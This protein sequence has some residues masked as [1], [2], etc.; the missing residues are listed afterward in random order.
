[1][2]VNISDVY[3]KTSL[4][5]KSETN[6]LLNSKSNS[7]I[8]TSYYTKTEIN[9]SFDNIYCELYIGNTF[10]DQIEIDEKNDILSTALVFKSIVNYIINLDDKINLKSDILRVYTKIEI[11]VLISTPK[12]IYN[13]SLK[14]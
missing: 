6:N 11:N 9:N 10:Y 5:I 7:S 3:L 12:I 8:I 13:S 1:M 14:T 2:E 4:Y